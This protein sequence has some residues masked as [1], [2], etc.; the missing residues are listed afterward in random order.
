[1]AAFGVVRFGD[2]VAIMADIEPY[3][4]GPDAASSKNHEQPGLPFTSM[5]VDA[6]LPHCPD[7]SAA[8][9]RPHCCVICDW[10]PIH[11]V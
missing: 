1:M 6:H 5:E 11:G 10:P 9:L 8:L 4:G 7:A 2:I 3:G